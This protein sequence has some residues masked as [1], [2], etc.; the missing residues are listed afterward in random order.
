MGDKKIRINHMAGLQLSFEPYRVAVG[1]QL[2]LPC[3]THVSNVDRN[4]SISSEL[5]VWLCI[6]DPFTP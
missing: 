2:D 5:P 3:Q 4:V 1:T 6:P